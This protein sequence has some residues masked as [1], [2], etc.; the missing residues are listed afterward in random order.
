[1]IGI[2]FRLKC[3]RSYEGKNKNMHTDCR[4][5]YLAAP[6]MQP[7]NIEVPFLLPSPAHRPP[8]FHQKMLP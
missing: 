6:A 1:M 4:G 3:T 2:E 8:P 5:G 7:S